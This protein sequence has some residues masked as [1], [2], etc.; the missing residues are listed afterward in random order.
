M[1]CLWTKLHHVSGIRALGKAYSLVPKV[2]PTAEG[3]VFRL[4]QDSMSI[5]RAVAKIDVM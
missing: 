1:Q 2:I 3:Y 5:V 4:W